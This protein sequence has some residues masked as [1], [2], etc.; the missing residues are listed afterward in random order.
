VQ[1]Y[2]IEH[3]SEKFPVEKLA[4]I[5]GTSPRTIA[6]LFV[7]ELSLTPHDYIEGVRLDQ[8]RNLLEATDLALKAVA[9]DCGFAGPEQMRAAFQRRIGISPQRYRESF[10]QGN[11]PRQA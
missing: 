8:A 11:A 1:S 4:K 3:V 7:K 10:R 9:F 5:A 2:V 6:R